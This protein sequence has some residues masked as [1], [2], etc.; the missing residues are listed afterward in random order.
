MDKGR[1]DGEKV[2]DGKESDGEWGGRERWI[3]GQKFHQNPSEIFEIFCRVLHFQ[4]RSTSDIE[5]L[6]TL[7]FSGMIVIRTLLSPKN[8]FLG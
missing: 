4:E 3:T 7:E 6:L 8:K 5:D 1:E 2:G